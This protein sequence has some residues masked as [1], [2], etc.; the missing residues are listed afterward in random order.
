MNLKKL[1][2]V[3][4]KKDLLNSIEGIP[5]VGALI[6][7]T[8]KEHSRQDCNEIMVICRHLEHRSHVIQ[9]LPI[10]RRRSEATWC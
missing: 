2:K 6:D 3:F 10:Q 4:A 1:I 5:G 9:V 8:R 7:R